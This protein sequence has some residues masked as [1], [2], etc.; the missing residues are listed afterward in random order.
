MN[1][2]R[3]FIAVPLVV[4]SLVLL[5]IGAAHLIDARWVGEQIGKAGYFQKA[6]GLITDAPHATA[7]LFYST[8][9][10][11]VI[12]VVGLSI[13]KRWL[14]REHKRFDEEHDINH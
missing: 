5:I 14:H 3:I 13:G 2:N 10:N 7:E 6:V 9:E 12:L 11:I 1:N 8:L 4:L